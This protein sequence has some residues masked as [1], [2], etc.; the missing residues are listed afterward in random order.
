[1]QLMEKANSEE[2]AVTK[3]AGYIVEI[4][5]S[6]VHSDNL[7]RELVV[8]DVLEQGAELLVPEGAWL[9]VKLESGRAVRIEGQPDGDRSRILSEKFLDD[10]VADTRT[11]TAPDDTAVEA[12][13]YAPSRSGKYVQHTSGGFDYD[14]DESGGGERQLVSVG[15]GE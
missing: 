1:M 10:A 9:V 12:T 5:G 8:G 6:V 2:G 4:E 11:E 15:P 13:R 3:V 7:E 14:R